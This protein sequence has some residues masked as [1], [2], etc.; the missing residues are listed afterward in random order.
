MQ[1]RLALHQRL[2]APIQAVE[3][4]QVERPELNCPR[5]SPTYVQP[6]KVW[7]PIRIARHNLAVEHGRFGRELVQQLRDGRK[8]LGEV[9]PVA[10][11]DYHPR[12]H[13]VDLHAVAVELHLV[14]PA[15]AG[16][17]FLG[18]DWA[19]GLD[20]AKRRHTDH[21]AAWFSWATP[22]V[23]DPGPAR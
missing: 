10:A 17:H 4:E 15:F 20:K 14:Q 13:F 16:G 1:A 7:A 22:S 11:V 6:G 3:S 18:A 9:V 5:P 23:L 2:R 12:A 21:L 8:A 19:A